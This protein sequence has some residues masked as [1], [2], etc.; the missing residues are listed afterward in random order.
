MA[1]KP[2]VGI[3][4]MQLFLIGL[5]GCIGMTVASI[6]RKMG[7]GFDRYEIALRGEQLEKPPRIFTKIE[8]EH[9]FWGDGITKGKI[10]Q[11]IKLARK[12]CP[13]TNMVEQAVKIEHKYE[14]YPNMKV[15]E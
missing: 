5:G 1:L 2:E 12:Y 10:E 15:I 9:K 3:K 7:M 13:I 11:G 6:L 14:I 8:I 4:P